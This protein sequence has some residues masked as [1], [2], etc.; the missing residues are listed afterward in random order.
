MNYI[1]SNQHRI[2]FHEKLIITYYF[3]HSSAPSQDFHAWSGMA[4][5]LAFVS[6]PPNHVSKS[7]TFS[8]LKK[9]RDSGIYLPKVCIVKTMVFPVVRYGWES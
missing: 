3:H 1:Y 2:L 7:W 6:G 8:V 4:A 5:E 9:Q